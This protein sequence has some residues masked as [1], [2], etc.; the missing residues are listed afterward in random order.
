MSGLNK[1][2]W[3]AMIAAVTAAPAAAQQGGITSGGQPSGLGM[4]S[5]SGALTSSGLS[6][7]LNNGSSGN[8]SGVGAGGLRGS[9][10]NGGTGTNGNAPQTVGD[11][12]ISAP[13][14]QASTSLDAS[15]RFGGY[16]ANPYYQGLGQGTNTPGGFGAPL[17]NTA[18]GGT[19]SRGRGTT[20]GTT[21]L[22]GARGGL[23]GQNANNQ[24]GIVV[25]LPAQI[26]Y[27]AVMR[28]PTPPVA[29]T[30]IH[31]EIRGVLDN[32]SL[33]SN[34][35]AVQII[36]DV[37]NNITLRGNV[38]DEDE[39]RLIEGIVRLTPGVANIANELSFPVASK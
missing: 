35:K 14:G 25:P 37:N 21:G 13:T 19:G 16:Y 30:K 3:A 15:N 7:G 32:S 23:G 6:A 39:A 2:A 18:A 24:S 5:G 31:T 17:F 20:F 9:S 12:G 38:K 34:G 22:G 1:W 28:F 26:N 10:R 29:P 27:V 4:G 33:V 11:N 36:T 8:S